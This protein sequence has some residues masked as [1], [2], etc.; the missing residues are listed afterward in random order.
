MKLNLSIAMLIDA[1][2]FSLL[3]LHYQTG[4]E[5]WLFIVC[6][7]VWIASL[8]VVLLYLGYSW[9]TRHMADL[10]DSAFLNFKKM[11]EY[12]LPLAK[13]RSTWDYFY[14]TFTDVLYAFSFLVLF[15]AMFTGIVM[16]GY[17]VTKVFFYADLLDNDRKLLLQ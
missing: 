8:P 17:M 2:L 5:V 16:A 12:H 10:E 3:Y 4:E 13:D 15:D 1:V 14:D 9:Y 6:S 11:H 7:F